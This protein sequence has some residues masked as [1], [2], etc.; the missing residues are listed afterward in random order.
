[1][2]KNVHSIIDYL[3]SYAKPET[4]AGMKQYGINVETAL[5]IPMPVLRRLAKEI[6]KNHE[7]A[8]QLWDTGIHE[9]RILAGLIDDPKQVTEDQLEWW[10]VD[11]DSW[12]VCDQVCMNLIDKTP[13]SYKKAMEWSV[14]DKEFV[15]RAGFAVMASLAFHD[16]KAPDTAFYPFLNRIAESSDDARNFVKKAVNWALR[17]IGKRNTPLN[18][19]AIETAQFILQ[20]NS[21]AARWIA[22]NALREL[23]GESVQKKLCISV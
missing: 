16:K 11:F 20:K 6:K 23:T 8:L 5:G 1:M 21:K 22:S 15:K 2:E 9:A 4:C 10:V 19:K 13:F 14:S 17:Q 7:L 12:D 18:Q 3:K